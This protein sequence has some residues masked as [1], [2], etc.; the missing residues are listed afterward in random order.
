MIDKLSTLIGKKPAALV[1][2]GKKPN[3]NHVLLT[4]LAAFGPMALLAGFIVLV[5]ILLGDRLLPAREVTVETVVTLR[6]ITGTVTNKHSGKPGD[7]VVTHPP[8][9]LSDGD[10]VSPVPDVTKNTRT[11]TSA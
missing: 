11:G 4:R 1:Q 8:D 2:S 7:K 3:S 5:W 6:S 9:D 10:R